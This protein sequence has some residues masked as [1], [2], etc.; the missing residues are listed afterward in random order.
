MNATKSFALG[1]I[2]ATQGLAGFM[3]SSPEATAFCFECID[4][5][6]RGDWGNL[7]AVDR[8]LNDLAVLDGCLRLLSAYQLPDCDT[9]RNAADGEC[10][11]WIITEDDRSATTLLWP[12][13]Y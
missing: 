6:R 8:K 7:E 4:R 9:L 5:H 10:K 2:V 12:S 1:H 3:Q 11:L 13:E